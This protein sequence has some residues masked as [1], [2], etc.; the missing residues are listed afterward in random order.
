V[1]FPTGTGTLQRV[2]TG[3]R[4]NAVLIGFVAACIALGVGAGTIIALHGGGKTAARPAPA[5]APHV[6]PISSP[7]PIVKP[8]EQDAAPVAN[9]LVP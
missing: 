4:T 9:R 8:L 2:T 5:A 1:T 7:R 3:V 6:E